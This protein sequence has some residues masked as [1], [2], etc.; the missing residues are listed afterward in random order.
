MRAVLTCER[1]RE[2]TRASIRVAR[3]VKTGGGDTRAET[4]RGTRRKVAGRVVAAA[5]IGSS[6]SS[7]SCNRRYDLCR[8]W[9]P[10]PFSTRR[11]RLMGRDND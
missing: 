7:S 1:P 3:Q 10:W 2:R 4:G 6:R 8:R 11:D 5:A 9:L